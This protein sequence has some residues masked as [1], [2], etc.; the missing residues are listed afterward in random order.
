MDPT[1]DSI[2]EL[3]DQLKRFNKERDWEQF[4]SPRNLVLALLGEAG[5]V[6]AEIQWV[7]DVEVPTWLSNVENVE[8]L[9]SELADVFAYLLQ[10]SDAVGVPLGEALV[11]K[12]AVNE[13]RYPVER[14]RGTSAKYG[15]Q[16][17]EDKA[18]S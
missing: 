1:T 12:I 16:A 2:D 6:A 13:V 7:P 14:S 10:L 4:H 8:R 9:A 18:R 5:E 3:I 17:A 11:K 15:Q